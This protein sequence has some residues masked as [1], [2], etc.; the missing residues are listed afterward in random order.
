MKKILLIL[1][2]SIIGTVNV[3]KSQTNPAPF[4]LRKGNYSLTSWDSLATVNTYPSN[5]IFRWIPLLMTAPFY[6]DSA[7]TNYNLAYNLTSGPRFNGLGK[8]GISVITTKTSASGTNEFTGSILLALNTT[9]RKNLQ[10]SWESQTLTVNPRAMSLRL[11]YRV[12][13]TGL[14]TD[15]PGPVQ[16]TSTAGATGLAAEDSLKIGPTALPV[17][18]ENQPYVDIF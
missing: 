11:Q 16:F 3:V 13:S 7:S 4:D 10:V 9:N 15:V 12:D 6:K 14:Y 8:N 5:M 17:S 1:V 2:I 18:C